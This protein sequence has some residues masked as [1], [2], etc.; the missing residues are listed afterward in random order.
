MGC[1]FD[2]GHFED[3]VANNSEVC[4][5]VVAPLTE[6]LEHLFQASVEEVKTGVWHDFHVYPRIGLAQGLE[7]AIGLDLL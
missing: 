7:L 2:I 4:V 1:R 6:S 5:S 3:S